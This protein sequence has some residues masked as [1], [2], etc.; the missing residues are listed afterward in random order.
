MLPF[1][2]Q[3]FHQFLLPTF[4]KFSVFNTF[5]PSTPSVINVVETV[6]FFPFSNFIA[7]SERSENGYFR[8]ENMVDVRDLAP[9]TQ[10]LA[11]FLT[12]LCS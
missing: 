7:L 10:K 6:T 1:R 2:F 4:F 9:K 5:F 3:T 11:G 8:S 12:S